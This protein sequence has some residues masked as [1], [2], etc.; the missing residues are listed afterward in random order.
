M[1]IS[2]NDRSIEP[3]E[4]YVLKPFKCPGAHLDAIIIGAADIIKTELT[5]DQSSESTFDLLAETERFF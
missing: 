4:V 2:L 3:S 5:R 1:G